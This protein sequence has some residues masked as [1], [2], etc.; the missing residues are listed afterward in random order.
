MESL[1]LL[2]LL[3][4][5]IVSIVAAIFILGETKS[6]S[7]PNVDFRIEKYIV[8][9]KY[10]SP[11]FSPVVLVGYYNRLEN[12]IMVSIS[13]IALMVWRK[14]LKKNFNDKETLE[15]EFINEF[16]RELDIV[17]IHEFTE[18]AVHQLGYRRFLTHD[19]WNQHIRKIY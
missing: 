2:G 12:S 17:L 6:R 8:S 1:T 4:S 7:N 10:V 15:Q 9:S 16:I 11:S 18:W 13:S 5:L 19:L 14:V 3:L